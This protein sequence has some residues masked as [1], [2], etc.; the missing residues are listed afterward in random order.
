MRKMIYPEKQPCLVG[1]CHNFQQVSSLSFSVANTQV[2]PLD[3]FAYYVLL[4]ISF[5]EDDND[6]YL[7]GAVWP[8][9][10][11]ENWVIKCQMI[12]ARR[13]QKSS[14]SSS[15]ILQ[16]GKLKRKFQLLPLYVTVLNFGQ[17]DIKKE[18]SQIQG[19]TKF[20]DYFFLRGSLPKSTVQGHTCWIPVRA[21]E[22][23][24][25]LYHT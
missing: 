21:Q 23:H 14:K 12:R 4:F 6:D 25:Y 2:L 24:T 11:K 16:M 8:K 19:S 5:E 9:Y 10:W 7:C 15:F 22:A 20:I 1:L 3:L 13:G 17:A 18:T